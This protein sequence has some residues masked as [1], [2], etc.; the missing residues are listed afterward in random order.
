MHTRTAPEQII[1]YRE[2]LTPSLGIL[3][4][5]ALLGPMVAIVFLPWRPEWSL[6]A[7]VATSLALM[8]LLWLASPKIEV[9][10]STLR[11]GRAHIEREWL[12]TAQALTGADA[13]AARTTQLPGNG[14]HLIRGGA[15]GI[16]RVRVNDPGDPVKMW[17]ISSRTPDRLAAAL[18]APQ[19]AS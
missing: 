14:W 7:G 11:V 9:S 8:G 10:G 4:A 3:G 1:R 16:V 2:R 13:R 6:L 18:N 19:R 17:T 15:D 12:G 5:T